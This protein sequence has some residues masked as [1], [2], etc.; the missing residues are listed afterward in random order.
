[1]TMTI[2]ESNCVTKLQQI[3]NLPNKIRH[4]ILYKLTNQERWRIS[5]VCKSWRSMVLNWQLH[6]KTLPTKS[7]LKIVPEDLMPYTAYIQRD[8]IKYLNIMNASD[9]T[10][11][12]TNVIDFLAEQCYNRIS[13]GTNFFP[14]IIFFYRYDNSLH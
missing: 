9:V 7:D 11:Y 13:Q 5:G 2:S 10:G 12:L 4:L 3:P 1:M 6:R 14:G 8:A